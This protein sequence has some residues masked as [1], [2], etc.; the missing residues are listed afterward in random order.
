M[1]RQCTKP[2]RK[3]DD[4]WF[5]EKVLLVQ[6]QAKRSKFLNDEELAF[7]VDPEYSPDGQSTQT[8]ITPY[9]AYQA[10]Y[11][12]AH[13]SDCD[14]STLP[15]LLS[16]RIY[17]IM[18]QDLLL[19]FS[20]SL[21][22]QKDSASKPKLYVGDIIVQTNPIMIPDS[23]ET[24]ALAEESHS[25]MLLKHKDNMMLEKKKQVDTTPIDYAALNQLYKDFPT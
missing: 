21:Y 17:L 13:D 19:R 15:K 11:L 16:W 12:D 1:S 14:N 9:A 24:L 18:V 10:D 8:V 7:L 20:K 3:R 22:L 23:E 2:K 5:K 6:A 25:K 4:S